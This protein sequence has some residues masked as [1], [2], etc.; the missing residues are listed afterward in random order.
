[1]GTD[2][3]VFIVK[4]GYTALKNALLQRGWIENPDKY[5]KLF[6]FKWTTKINDIEFASL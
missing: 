4:G 6:D 1:M 3:K 2:S 5:S